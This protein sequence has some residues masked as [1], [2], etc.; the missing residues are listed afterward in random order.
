MRLNEKLHYHVNSSWDQKTGGSAD[1]GR[2][3]IPFDTPKEYEGN[4]TAPCPDQLF[5]ASLTGC[6]MNTF[7]YYKNQLG[8]VTLD[9]VVD[10]DAEVTM[11]H[12]HGYRM[13]KLEFKLSIQCDEED[14]ELNQTC[15][16]RAR[17]YCHLTK[18]IE[19][20]IPTRVTIEINQS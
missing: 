2:F 12:P 11:K 18:T 8:A 4:E 7:L 10:A 6:L 14:L 5:L 16:E 19:S 17:D 13:T 3:V 20:T 1:S 9:I 15:A